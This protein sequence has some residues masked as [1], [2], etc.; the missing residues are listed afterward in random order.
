MN[1]NAEWLI[2]EDV[3]SDQEYLVHLST[4]R[5]VCRLYAGE[6]APLSPFTYSTADG[7]TLCEFRWVDDQPMGVELERLL[8]EAG[9]AITRDSEKSEDVE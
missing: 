2:G 4:P 6:D 8:A 9:R 5:F 3:D 7:D 1:T